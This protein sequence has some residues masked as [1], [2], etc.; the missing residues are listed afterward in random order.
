[1]DKKRIGALRQQ[2]YKANMELLEK[3]L[4]ISTF[5]NVSGMD[6]ELGL[7]AIKPSGVE[8]NTLSFKDMVL[9]DA[10]G[11]KLE[12][13]L[14]PSSDTKTHVRLYRAFPR[15]GGVVHTH[16]KFATAWAQAR[17]PLPCYGTTHA[18][19][20]HGEVPCTEVITDRQIARD[21]EE[22]TAEQILQAF[23]RIDYVGMP[24]VIVA[25]HGPFSWGK[26][27]AEAVH[28]AQMLEY[29]A[30]MAFI[31]RTLNKRI[32][33][34]KRTLLDKHFMRKHGPAAYYGQ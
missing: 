12:G 32:K 6:R 17:L 2:V 33:G 4:I 21:Y 25:S 9:L 8:Y 29:A 28:Y 23:R 22:E 34:V 13:D 1:M 19:Y 7:I 15:I 26:D 30:E 20:F 16:S 24:A 27:P 5:G 10:E 3:G 14:N 11:K 31:C 18:D